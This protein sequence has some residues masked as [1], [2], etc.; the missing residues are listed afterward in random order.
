MPRNAVTGHIYTGM[1]AIVLG[2]KHSKQIF[3][4]PRWMT[5]KQA[6][7]Q[8][9]FV[10]KDSKG[11]RAILC[12]PNDLGS[13]IELTF[14]HYVLFHASQVEGV[15]PYVPR[16]YS[17]FEKNSKAERIIKNSGAIIQYGG[18]EAFY[19][20]APDRIKLPF[21][22]NFIDQ[23]YYYATALHKLAHWTGHK[24]RLKRDLSG[25]FSS[26]KYAFEELVAEITS[27]FVS[28][29]TG[30]PQTK[31]HFDNHATYIASWL[32]I[33]TKDLKALFRAASLA[34]AASEYIL[35]HEHQMEK[36]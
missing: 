12:I 34:Q 21:I 22:R 36:K 10:K 25:Q 11:T 27:M 20:C 8:G 30:I 7:S 6:Q 14:S 32:N 5:Y 2:L 15:P 31:E 18:H 16:I 28:G 24:N 13:R 1:N 35:Q 29:E 17:E 26:E 33:F 19:D 4:A 9:W 23:A 3:K